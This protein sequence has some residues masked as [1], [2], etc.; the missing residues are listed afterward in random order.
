MELTLRPEV[1]QYIADQ[2]RAGRFDS[3]EAVVEAAIAELTQADTAPEP[4][5]AADLAAIAEA[6]AEAERGEGT[7]LD[8]FRAEIAKRFRVPG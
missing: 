5:D 6:D 1:E 7:D 4:L 3:P 8:A 2:V